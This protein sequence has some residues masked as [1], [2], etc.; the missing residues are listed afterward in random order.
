[1]LSILIPTYNYNISALVKEIHSQCTKLNI[2]F[3]IICFDDGSNSDVNKKNNEINKLENTYF[4]E[5]DKNIGR[6]AIRNMLAKSAKHEWLLFL[7]ADVMPKSAQFIQ[8]YFKKINASYEAIFGG[9]AYE[10]ETPENDSILRW[11]YGKKY[12]EVDAKKRN[13]KPHQLIISANFLISK[14]IFIKINS[15]INRKSY[16]LDNYFASLLKQ[17]N[18]K[19]FHLNNEV[20]HHGLESS[21][22]YLNK[23]EECINT[24]LWAYNQN[25]MSV[26]DNKLLGMFLIFKKAKL[27]YFMN[28]FHKV[29]K[30]PM[31]HNLLSPNPNIQLL[32][33]Y[34]LSYICY[35][36]L[37]S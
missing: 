7:D 23:S 6:S 26:H 31:K 8:N 2:E 36:D 21:L 37:A 22:T 17:Y 15:L 34:K 30:D 18:I 19:V 32:Q 29:F 14:E 9:F 4:K 5:L 13:L 1:M 20:Y 12:E 3:E 28:Y 27:H 10:K 24:L 25:K 11:K 35:K 33:V 16:G